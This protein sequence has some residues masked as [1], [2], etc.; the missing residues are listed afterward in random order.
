RINEP[1]YYE[2]RLLSLSDE[3]MIPKILLLKTHNISV[4]PDLLLEFSA[5]KLARN[6]RLLNV[7]GQAIDDN[8]IRMT[9]EEMA[10]VLVA[11]ITDAELKDTEL[12]EISDFLLEQTVKIHIAPF[13][14]KEIDGYELS[15][16]DQKIADDFIAA[17]LST[18]LLTEGIK[19][20]YGKAS[21][22]LSKEIS[23]EKVKS[24]VESALHRMITKIEGD[25]EIKKLL[26]LS[27]AVR[28][29][30]RMP[31][32]SLRTELTEAIS[33][34]KIEEMPEGIE[35]L[36][37]RF[38]TG[39]AGKDIEGRHLLDM[40]RMGFVDVVQETVNATGDKNVIEVFNRYI[41]YHNQVVE[42]KKSIKEY[43]A[44]KEVHA[45]KSAIRR[46]AEE[47]EENPILDDEKYLFQKDPDKYILKFLKS[48]PVL[49][50]FGG[51]EVKKTREKMTAREMETFRTSFSAHKILFDAQPYS[52]IL[53]IPEGVAGKV[54]AITG[55]I[56][57]SLDNM[58]SG[59]PVLRRVNTTYLALFV[60]ACI[61]MILI[62]VITMAAVNPV[63]GTDSGGDRGDKQPGVFS[64]EAV[65]FLLSQ[66]FPDTLDIQA[67][68]QAIEVDPMIAGDL[69]LQTL[70]P[71]KEIIPTKFAEKEKRYSFESLDKAVEIAEDLYP[72]V[73]KNLDSLIAKISAGEVLEKDPKGMVE[74]RTEV[75]VLQLALQE[76]LSDRVLVDGIFKQGLYANV[77]D[78][79]KMRGLP[80][81][82]KV[83]SETT[84]EIVEALL[85]KYRGLG[86]FEDKRELVEEISL[87]APVLVEPS[88]VSEIPPLVISE[89]A[90]KK[91]K[92]ETVVSAAKKEQPVDPVREI[93]PVEEP[94]VSIKGVKAPTK[95][96]GVPELINLVF[97]A[98]ETVRAN[99]LT[100]IRDGEIE[101]TR[102]SFN[103]WRVDVFGG[104][105][106]LSLEEPG[107]GVKLQLIN[108]DRRRGP[109]V[110]RS[111]VIAEQQIFKERMIVQN[112][113]AE[114]LFTYLEFKKAKSRESMLGES[115]QNAREYL[116]KA[117][118]D[119]SAGIRSSSESEQMSI[120][121]DKLKANLLQEKSRINEIRARIN[122]LI[123][124]SPDSDIT[125]S[126]EGKVNIKGI[127]DVLERNGIDPDVFWINYAPI[128]EELDVTEVEKARLLEIADSKWRGAF[129]VSIGVAPFFIAPSISIGH[130]IEA[131]SKELFE[132]MKSMEESDVKKKRI[133]DSYLLE[134]L[135]IKLNFLVKSERELAKLIEAAKDE[136]TIKQEG[137]ENGVIPF[138][139][140]A[141]AKMDL[142][143]MI[144]Y[145]RAV[146]ASIEEVSIRLK[147]LE[148]SEDDKLDIGGTCTN[149]SREKCIETE[150]EKGLT[151]A[152]TNGG[153]LYRQ[154]SGIE[155]IEEAGEI[156]QEKKDKGIWKKHKEHIEKV[157]SA[158]KAASEYAR[159]ASQTVL[160][161]KIARARL[162]Y[163]LAME[164]I[165]EAKNEVRRV[166][167]EV[168]LAVGRAIRPMESINADIA[169]AKIREYRAEQA[170]LEAALVLRMLTS[171]AAE[172]SSDLGVSDGEEVNLKEIDGYI[173][174]EAFDPMDE[175]ATLLELEA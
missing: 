80:V 69:S 74:K 153:V 49:N 54:V 143:E 151:S 47:A 141:A 85:E 106:V 48:E 123:G 116:E 25:A 19:K 146:M 10:K 46:L 29:F 102:K 139:V 53:P 171:Y 3:K 124:L 174:S 134:N 18:I 140:N 1:N 159:K 125:I 67:I 163:D 60:V 22:L 8:T 38:L 14:K 88:V 68:E 119:V 90:P 135:A 89:S 107:V 59:V 109:A 61:G 34:G 130:G 99:M 78:F 86:K 35:G 12:V 21:N 137:F 93:T 11:V 2:G 162:E 28:V 147:Q 52:R 158:K 55:R 16:E 173:G 66:N 164:E 150:L 110:E 101:S 56:K 105:D 72:R 70:K 83:D 23:E 26:D 133:E 114:V 94:E 77:R 24:V 64:P 62:P 31:N 108:L 30:N 82:G 111:K 84:K 43:Q 15:P 63:V 148:S 100:R 71:E 95:A 41:K 45:A 170:V 127:N 42:V 32:E 39:D 13:L 81:T 144:S 97:E 44:S 103:H 113:V 166:R 136:A 121:I 169:E 5:K 65:S 152:K 157:L 9:P 161:K 75:T 149:V 98:P 115:L 33:L 175:Q 117:E 37:T 165:N 122:N 92:P 155:Y 58:F 50:S 172:E 142:V 40:A 4:E 131:K 156:V 96:A 154:E 160:L 167:K 87:K 20:K 51:M 145:R 7:L 138:V 17:H 6:I 76:I 126:I 129:G 91:E 27:I 112:L 132:I 128:I 57:Q 168:K 120:N 36:V 73:V 118:K 104:V 79:Q